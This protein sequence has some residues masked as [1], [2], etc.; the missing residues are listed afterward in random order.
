MCY[1]I[2]FPGNPHGG[3]STECLPQHFPESS[4][5]RRMVYLCLQ[6]PLTQD[7]TNQGESNN[8]LV[9][10]VC[11]HAPKSLAQTMMVTYMRV[12][13]KYMY[14]YIIMRVWVVYVCRM[15]KHLMLHSMDWLSVSWGRL[16]L[17]FSSAV[18]WCSQCE[19]ESARYTQI[20]IMYVYT[21]VTYVQC[22]C[23]SALKYYKFNKHIHI[24]Y[25]Y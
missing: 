20:H 1:C 16:D 11:L 5:G 10:S 22:Y 7:P 19:K 15:I 18:S 12:T 4:G 24:F 6:P 17:R 13:V 2:L 8:R 9:P 25:P 21:S 3:L 14:M 23:S